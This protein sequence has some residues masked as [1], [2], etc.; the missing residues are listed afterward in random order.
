MTTRQRAWSRTRLVNLLCD[1]R[2]LDPV[3]GWTS[4]FNLVGHLS[5]EQL[6]NE[7]RTATS[8]QRQFRAE[9]ERLETTKP[10]RA[11]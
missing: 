9:R 10:A 1:E 5:S 7:V 2:D 6:S 8:R 11:L 4:I 3:R